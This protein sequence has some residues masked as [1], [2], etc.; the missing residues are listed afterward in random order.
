VR[1]L[2]R[3]ADAAEVQG[4]H[5]G[6]GGSAVPPQENGT[7]TGLQ[8]IAFNTRVSRMEVA[9]SASGEWYVH[10]RV[11]DDCFQ[12]ACLTMEVCLLLHAYSILL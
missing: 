2:C 12:Y 1:A 4:L 9:G 11:A 3:L 7:F 6:L 8:M 5:T 10:R